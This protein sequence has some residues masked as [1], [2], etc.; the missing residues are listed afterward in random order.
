MMRVH[1]GYKP[2]RTQWEE[3]RNSQSW[4]YMD[5]KGEYS[6]HIYFLSTT[7]LI[8]FD[9]EDNFWFK[10]IPNEEGE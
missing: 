4:Y 7:L 5:N 6:D 8:C 9:R 1:S 3:I 2:T 10:L